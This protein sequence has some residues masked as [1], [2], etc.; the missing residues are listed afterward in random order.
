MPLKFDRS[1]IS[2]RAW[3]SALRRGQLG[4][5]LAAAYAKG[6]ISKA[7]LREVYGTVPEEAFNES[8]GV[9]SFD[10][11]K[12]GAPHHELEGESLI[13]NADGLNAAAHYLGARGA[14]KRELSAQ[15][16]AEAR[17]HILNE[18]RR[19]DLT[20]PA[21]FKLPRKKIDRGQE[22]TE[23][24]T[25]GSMGYVMAQ[26][27]DDFREQF[28]R[29]VVDDMMG[30][31]SYGSETV[32]QAP[33]IVDGEIFA[34]Y[35]IVRD[36]D[37][38]EGEYYKVAYSMQTGE[39]VF[40]TR[41]KWEPVE[42]T[43]Q[44][45][46]PEA[47]EPEPGTIPAATGTATMES[48]DDRN[49]H[50]RFNERLAGA[51]ELV[52]SADDN[53]N[54]P[55]RIQGVGI[56]ADVVNGNRRRYSAAV[57][58]AAVANMKSHLNESAGQGRLYQ[59]LG[60]PEHPSQKSGRPSLTETVVRWTDIRFDGKQVLL[61]GNLLGT[62]LGRD[63]RAQMKGGVIPDI[64]QRSYG[65]SQSIK[66]G[67]EMV[68]DVTECV[69]TGYDLIANG[70]GS[71]PAARVTFVESKNTEATVDPKEMKAL[72]DK[73][74]EIFT[75]LFE[76]KIEEL[77]AAQLKK[78]EESLR[79]KLGL[80]E[81]DDLAK[82]LDEAVDARKQLAEMKH[83][84][85]IDEA[86]AVST[87]D[88]PYGKAGNDR[89]VESVKAAKPADAAAVKLL[90]EAKRKEYDGLAADLKLQGM[91]M[92][93]RMLGS[94]LENELG[95]PDYARMSHVFGESLVNA[96][97]VVRHDLKAPKTRSEFYCKQLLERFDKLHQRELAREAR[98]LDEIETTADL[99][100]PYSVS[101]M[102]I[103]FAVP[104]FM[105]PNIFDTGPTD[106]APARI[107]FE[108]RAQETGVNVVITDEAVVAGDPALSEHQSTAQWVNLA[109]KSVKRDGT[110]FVNNNADNQ[111]YVEGT[112]Y[113]IDYFNG[114]ILALH[115]GAIAS[116]D[117]LKVDYHYEA[118]RLGENV[119]IERGKTTL[120][121]KT[122]EIAA[123]RLATQLT[124]EAIAFS[125][126]QIGWDAV[127]RNLAGLITD[128]QVKIDNR[129]FELAAQV[130]RMIPGNVA[131]T[132]DHVND[133]VDNLVQLLGTAKNFVATR[134]YTPTFIIMSKT[135]SDLLANW[136][137]PQG[138]VWNRPDA[139]LL[140]SGYTG[141][142][143]GLPV[144]GTVLFN[145]TEII[146]GNK[147]LV[148]YRVF[149]PMLIKGPF[150]TYDS[151]GKLIAADQYYTEEYN[152]ADSP[153][154]EKGALVLAK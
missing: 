135:N 4:I 133:P 73:H 47:P 90:V 68:E 139:E 76:G 107:Y 5:D 132:W 44:P 50:K 134:Y 72:F 61:E 77:G 121:F 74:P 40:A 13:L 37:C 101:R 145:D 103:Q 49:G 43:Y 75:G 24:Q 149:Q 1:R 31:T 94:V 116:G 48:R 109:H 57:L 92:N 91:G 144:F 98:L 7:G 56:T 102:V 27:Y 6:D 151:T 26:I 110:L 25:S 82:A 148:Q 93:P 51:L 33:Y 11:S 79:S 89:F 113:I 21:A 45:R 97:L 78:L 140:G 30:L 124:S 146:I 147:E 34:D 152:G 41:E 143:K 142:I 127:N 46:Q 119:A 52:E 19:Q 32:M 104:E 118:T 114:R 20:P 111:V 154:P 81:K 131:G 108:D 150:P 125:R 59:I 60:E 63:I 86:I 122:L 100:I 117:T 80:T 9:P 62:S 15:A 10:P 130:V 17:A 36:A 35:V 67:A 136:G 115:N 65:D 14:G 54:G 28:P 137:T 138:L 112:D 3:G 106:Q 53:P 69:I 39:Y 96:G 8:A 18:Y 105:A 87:K 66:V 83:T 85:E 88:L 23:A 12:A 29:T 84:K 58:A 38:D 129:L 16:F 120:A 126:S 128:T 141:R 42:L 99:N 22:L 95:I 2:N 153:K 64:S 55:W 123:D 70:M 71:D